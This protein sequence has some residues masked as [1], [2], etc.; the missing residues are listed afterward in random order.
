[1]AEVTSTTLVSI[2][3]SLVS[4]TALYAVIF[5]IFQNPSFSTLHV[6]N[7]TMAVLHMLIAIGM[8]VTHLKSKD[9]WMV[10]YLS[11]IHI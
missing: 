8:L 2:V 3:I 4:V 10:F 5:R 6:T 9:K 1:M 11:L 7:V